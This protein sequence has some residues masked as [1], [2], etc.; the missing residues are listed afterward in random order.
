MKDEKRD[1]LREDYS[2]E[3]I[4]SGVR[5][6]YAAARCVATNPDRENAMAQ[7]TLEE[8]EDLMNRIQ[9]LIKELV[10][11]DRANL[12]LSQRPRGSVL[13][14]PAGETL[15]RLDGVQ[16]WLHR[17]GISTGRIKEFTKAPTAVRIQELVAELCRI[18]DK[19]V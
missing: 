11:L 14:D 7:M 18:R 15:A 10:E 4:R 6:K 3:L 5:G 12:R 8:R 1:E 13:E 16:T 19:Y 9:P 17:R 2:E